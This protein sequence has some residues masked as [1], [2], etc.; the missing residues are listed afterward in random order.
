MNESVRA[1]ARPARETWVLLGLL[2]A[3]LAARLAFIHNEGFKTDVSTY[4]AW[5]IGL[6]QHGFANF[7]ATAGFADYPPGYFYVLAVIGHLWQAAFAAHDPSFAVLR[8]LVKVPAILADLGAAV[9]LYAVVRRFAAAPFAAIA[10]A[11]Y[12]FNP[13]TLTISAIWGQV[14]SISGLF[15]LFAI[16]AL[17]RSSDATLS[18]RAAKPALS[19]VEGRAHRAWIV[20]AWLAFG[21]S[22]LIK[23]QAAVLL[24]LI[25][26]F[27]FVDPARRRQRLIASAI[28]AA[29]AIVLA[30]LVT[31]PFH[32]SNPIA[33]FGWLLERYAYGSNVYPYN[34]VNAFNLWA[35][36]GTFW[37]PDSQYI[38]VLPQWGWG[39]LLVLAGLTLIVWRYLQQ[40]SAESLL[41][42]CAI[43][44]LAFF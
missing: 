25:V 12:L 44:T 9:V 3:G 22:L 35:L 20:G 7:Y 16:Y 15:A 27:A 37:V 40:R 30:L 28:G 5:A 19:G 14:D 42:G 39:M 13:A 31:E 10:A 29:A 11:L 26:A 43:A 18:S 38:F 24:P 1:A 6:S 32:P 33:A 36:R 4:A 41:E 8:A 34:S 21:Y 23:P 2:L 17:L